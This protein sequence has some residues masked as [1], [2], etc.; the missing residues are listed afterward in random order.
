MAKN[1]SS[2]STFLMSFMEKRSEGFEFVFF[3]F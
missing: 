2:I 1:K 3:Y